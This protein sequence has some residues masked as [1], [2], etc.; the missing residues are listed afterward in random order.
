[1]KRGTKEGPKRRVAKGKR[2]IARPRPSAATPR[3]A[4]PAAIAP[5]Q[6]ELALGPKD[7]VLVAAIR[8]IASAGLEGINVRAI[9]QA[10]EV[11]VAAINYYFG[12]KDQ[13]VQLA[14]ERT[15]EESLVKT[16][17]EL[18]EAIVEAGG[19]VRAALEPFLVTLFGNAMRHPGVAA[20]HFDNVLRHQDYGGAMA[21]AQEFFEGFHLR[22]RPAFGEV[23]DA[24][25]RARTAEILMA[26]NLSALAPRLFDRFLSKPLTEEAG[27]RDFIGRMLRVHLPTR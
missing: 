13:L 27:L 3:R 18:D 17:P 5:T 8:C 7:R 21:R 26:L 16:L 10:A 11:N 4:R 2:E 25:A 6:E 19:D 1:M 22:I 23:D 24:T 9:A 20:V 14:L 15:L 12:S